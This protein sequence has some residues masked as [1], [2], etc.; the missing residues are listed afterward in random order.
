MTL[1]CLGGGRD[2]DLADLRGPM[3]VNLWASV[4]RAVPRRR[5]RCSQRSTSS[6]ATGS[7]SLGIDYQDTAARAAMELVPRP[8]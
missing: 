8:G 1:P 7:P 6:T 5:C 4:V 2:V 3:V